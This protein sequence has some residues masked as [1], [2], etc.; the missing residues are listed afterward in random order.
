MFLYK[1]IN[2]C[3]LVGTLK[4]KLNLIH[5]ECREKW[6]QGYRVNNQVQEHLQEM[7]NTAK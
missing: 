1:Y 7:A 4:H 3:S 6:G 5:N 2:I